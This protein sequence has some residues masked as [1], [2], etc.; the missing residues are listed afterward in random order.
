MDYYD[1]F[2]AENRIVE[3]VEKKTKDLKLGDSVNIE[4]QPCKVS[5]I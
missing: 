3:A 5:F 4:A 2:D 1:G